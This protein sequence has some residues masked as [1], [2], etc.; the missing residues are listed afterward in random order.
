MRV[1]L[2]DELFLDALR[3]EPFV[4]LILLLDLLL[5]EPIPISIVARQV[6]RLRVEPLV[7]DVVRARVV[8]MVNQERQPA[9]RARRVVQET[10]VVTRGTQRC[11][12]RQ[13]HVVTRVGRTVL[14]H[15]H[16]NHRLQLVQLLD[17]QRIDLLQAYQHVL[18]QLQTVVLVQHRIIRLHH[19]ILSQLGRQQFGEERTLVRTL[20]ADEH[21]HHVVHH[22]VVPHRRHHTHQPAFE[23][24]DEPLLLLFAPSQVVSLPRSL[25]I[26]RAR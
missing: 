12:A 10:L 13:V 15:R 3:F 2:H 5:R 20:I 1:V 16:R 14:D 17:R 22:L 6:E 8:D 24:F 21:Q 25:I 11:D 9:A 18:R 4:M 26:R 19:E 23:M 7:V